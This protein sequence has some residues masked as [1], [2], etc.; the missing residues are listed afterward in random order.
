MSL[1]NC[2]F[3]DASEERY[4][5]PNIPFTVNTTNLEEGLKLAY[6]ESL[7][8]LENSKMLGIE[9]TDNHHKVEISRQA[10]LNPLTDAWEAVA[11]VMETKL[12]I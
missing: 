6:W 12:G 7:D 3:Y 8:T 4:P 2:Q 1:I 11:T 9:Y 5:Y 10:L